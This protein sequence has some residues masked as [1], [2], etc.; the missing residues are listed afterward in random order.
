[1]T[2]DGL[3]VVVL[4]YGT[5]GEYLAVLRALF[6]Q[7]VAP[8]QILL[9]HNPSQMGERLPEAPAGC[10]VLSAS[11]NLGYAAGMNLG[12][13]RQLESGRELL[14]LLTHDARLR[15]GALAQLVG[16]ARSD[17]GYGV[18]GPLLVLAGSN[19]PFSFGGRTGMGGGLRHRRDRPTSQSEVTACDWI[20]GGTMLIRADALDGG[21]EFDERLW[22]Y[23]EDAD[24][25]LR[26]GRAGF[27]VGV[28]VAAIAEQSPGGAKRPGPWAY[29]LARNGLAFAWRSKG[30]RGVI[31]GMLRAA[32]LVV[33]ELI[34]SAARLTPLRPGPPAD[35]WAVAVGTARGVFDFLRQSWGPPPPGLPG[36]SDMRNL[37]A[38]YAGEVANG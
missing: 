33:S 5:G 35:T 3:G 7:G 27:G 28:V 2:Y 15:P 9:V 1:M 14:L 12:I 37:S 4:V 18:L 36:G 34:R 38:P 26:I 20:D 30:F 29:L 19:V 31:S 17:S 13:R 10:E 32:W 24:L 8:E 11:H 23:C 22:S 25:C 21:R 16:A 6:E